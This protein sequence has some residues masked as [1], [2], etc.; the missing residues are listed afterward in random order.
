MQDGRRHVGQNAARAHVV[1]LIADGE[2][3]YGLRRVVGV[4][5]A[6]LLVHHPLAVAVVGGDDG[7]AALGVD[8]RHQPPGALVHRLDRLDGRLQNAGVA[9]HVG[10][11]EV[12]QHEV[13]VAFVDPPDDLVH[14]QP[15]AHLRLKIVG[16]HLGR[17]LQVALL[18]LK[19]GFL[20]AVEEVG[21]VGVLLRLGGV[22]LPAALL[23]QH[24]GQRVGDLDFGE[25]HLHRVGGLIGSHRDQLQI[26]HIEPLEAN[27]IGIG[28][29]S[30]D[31]AHAVGAEVVED[32]RVARL[33]EH[34]AVAHVDGYRQNE[35]VGHALGVGHTQRGAER[36][37]GA[38]RRALF[39]AMPLVQD[40]VA[41]AHLGARPTLVAV[42]RVVA[43]TDRGD[44]ARMLREVLL[45]SQRVAQGAF[46]RR[47]AAV[48][49]DVEDRLDAVAL[50]H[51]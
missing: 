40:D 51:R 38:R 16:R 28:E 10:I 4:R 41:V 33:D 46:R 13:V 37:R 21:H 49:D 30:D 29:G 36:R 6:R 23:A 19:R 24:F 44:D 48:G 43:A 42:H 12:D 26:G 45:Q 5:L 27:E 22:Q 3:R 9:D 35:L 18:A 11:G 8:G 20:A 47:V 32:D 17:R 15:S 1:V 14:Q 2:Q 7:H 39:A 34:V 31:L 50:G 25:E